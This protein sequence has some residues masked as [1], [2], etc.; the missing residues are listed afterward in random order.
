MK[1]DGNVQVK[2]PTM[3]NEKRIDDADDYENDDFD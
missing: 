2:S 1:E 3:R